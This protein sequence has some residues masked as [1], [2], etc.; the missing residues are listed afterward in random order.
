MAPLRSLS[1]REQLR[2]KVSNRIS[3]VT[4][5]RFRAFLAPAVSGMATVQT[6]RAASAVASAEPSNAVSTTGDGTFLVSPRS[7]VQAMVDN[8][9]ANEEFLER[10]TR[11]PAGPCA[12][13][14]VDPG[15]WSDS[16]G[17]TCEDGPADSDVREEGPAQDPPPAGDRASENW[18]GLDALV[19]AAA[20]STAAP[21]VAGA[22]GSGQA[23][24]PKAASVGP[25]EAT[26]GSPL[27][28]GNGGGSA[29]PNPPEGS[30]EAGG[31]HGD[32]AATAS[33]AAQPPVQLCFGMDKGGRTSTVK[34]FLGIANQR[35]PASVGNSIVLAVFP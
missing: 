9:V 11:D 32:V 21:A 30:T 33:R 3:G 34:A 14:G 4:W 25:S 1:V 16:T 12:G 13:D 28:G 29:T 22:T 35:Q 2:F 5:S 27:A 17:S 20:R 18:S 23:G 8:L 24:A 6:L 19:T 31:P 26:A 15:T 7:A 10:P